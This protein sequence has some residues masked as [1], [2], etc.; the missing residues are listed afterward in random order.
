VEDDQYYME[1]PISMQNMIQ[2]MD[3]QMKSCQQP[4]IGR[5]DWVKK[6]ED[7]HPM[8]GNRLT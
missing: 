4:P 3:E 2:W 8:R 7:M 6:K 5:Q 1:P